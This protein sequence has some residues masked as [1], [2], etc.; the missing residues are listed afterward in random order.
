MG[1]SERHNPPV[2]I[3]SILCP[4][5]DPAPVLTYICEQPFSIEERE[6]KRTIRSLNARKAPGADGIT[7]RL[8][9]T[10]V[11]Q[12]TLVLTDVYNWSLAT[13]KLPAG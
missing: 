13:R 7:P 5:T 8:L 9:Q 12:L 1:T 11:D 6:V 4:F 10:G 3:E 2:P